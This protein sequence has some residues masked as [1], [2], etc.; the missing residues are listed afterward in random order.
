MRVSRGIMKTPR[1]RPKIRRG[2]NTGGG[3]VIGLSR[4]GRV[5]G[6]EV[7]EWPSA[8]VGVARDFWF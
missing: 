4:A 7:C 6:S 1:P 8:N 5:E 3:F 2:K